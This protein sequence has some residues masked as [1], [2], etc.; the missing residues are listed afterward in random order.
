[1]D[2]LICKVQRFSKVSLALVSF[3]KCVENFELFN[4][5]ETSCLNIPFQF[6]KKVGIY[7]RVIG[8]FVLYCLHT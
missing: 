5:L 2:F 3:I 4:N 6:Q 7:A 1:M 8:Q